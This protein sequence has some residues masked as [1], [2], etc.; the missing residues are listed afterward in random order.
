MAPREEAILRAGARR[1]LIG[2][3][4]ATRNRRIRSE[5]AWVAVEKAGEFLLVFLFLKLQTQFLSTSHYAEFQL[6]LSIAMLLIQVLL[7]PVRHSYFRVLHGAEA[8]GT[9][10]SAGV[11]LLAWYVPTTLALGLLGLVA[12][13]E[14]GHALGL[15]TAT[16]VGTVWVFVANGWRTLGTQDQ[17]FR[18]QRRTRTVHNLA[19]L[20]AHVLTVSA[21]LAWYRASAGTAL[22]TY[23]ITA[24]IFALWSVVPMIR[25]ILSQPKCGPSD[26]NRMVL[27]FGLPYAGLLLC[28]WLQ[29]FADRFVILEILDTDAVGRYDAAY[30]VAGIP[31]MLMHAILTALVV[32]VA[33]QRAK[34]VDD[35]HQLW[36]ADRILIAAVIVY[37][38]IGAIPLPIY[39]FFGPQL[40]LLL[41]QDNYIVPAGVIGLLAL[42]RYLQCL[43]FILQ[44]MFAVHHNM[45]VSLWLRAAGGFVLVP[46]CWYSTRWWG[47]QGAAIGV[48]TGGLLYIALV[49]FGPGGCVRMVMDARRK[50]RGAAAALAGSSAQS[51]R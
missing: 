4:S 20:V 33:Y 5:A 25:R 7:M 8:T 32:P 15:G 43:G 37:M 46:I 28:Q 22:F 24:G 11:A 47:L 51:G 40:M 2:A 48:F 38:V 49:L 13:R 31:Y 39:L 34:Q 9:L 19:F 14:V 44:A 12:G 3:Y 30:K 16:I 6:A 29:N 23:A 50:I 1:W 26:I 36:W 27:K 18:R 35:P 17:E 41:T 10:R 21:A 42:T 45:G